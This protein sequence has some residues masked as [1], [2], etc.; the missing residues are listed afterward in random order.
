[1]ES[2]TIPPPQPSGSIAQRPV[3][4]LGGGAASAAGQDGG[5]QRH[6]P[7]TYPASNLTD[8]YCTTDHIS[9]QPIFSREQHF[10]Y[11]SNQKKS[12]DDCGVVH[13][14]IVCSASSGH[15]DIYK[16]ITCN[17]PLCPV[18]F[19]K[20]VHRMADKVSERVTG[21]ESVYDEPETNYEV[22][23]YHLVLSPPQRTRY[24]TLK[25]AYADATRVFLDNGGIAAVFCFHPY[26][27][28]EG[29]I[30][31]LRYYQ[32]EWIRCNPKKKPPGFWKLA[33][34]DVLK[35]GGLG[36]YIVYSPH[37]HALA[38]GTL[39]TNKKY[40]E[41]PDK[42]VVFYEHGKFYEDTG[43][44]I[45][46]KV[47]RDEGADNL[48]KSEENLHSSIYDL[49]KED[50]DSVLHYLLTHACWEATKSTVRYVGAMSYSKLARKDKKV[51]RV[52]KTCKKCGA[53][54]VEHLVNQVTG[55]LGDC[56]GQEVTEKM[57]TWTYYK[58]IPKERPKK[59]SKAKSQA[60]R[61][62][63]NQ[64]DGT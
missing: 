24:K 38:S 27:F 7:N 48:D 21:F 22:P 60:N 54:L 32:D 13:T 12:L 9:V 8:Y 36:N 50:R 37:F 29:M 19:T 56:T 14:R 23:I 46:K 55:E 33:R 49:D 58:R 47:L 41:G 17:D 42:K 62:I 2:A 4:P 31:R 53:P 43:G 5:S 57:I 16:H 64:R 52:L 45:Y 51:E 35:L 40:V 15:T 63:G 1:M 61:V 18:C 11:G 44:W 34:E 30:P 3:P 6:Q 28:G 26:R 39:T 25:E 10:I 20:F 59:D